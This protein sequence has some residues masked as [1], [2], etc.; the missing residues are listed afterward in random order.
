MAWRS[1]GEEQFRWAEK[2]AAQGGFFQ[3]GDC[4]RRGI[5][6]KED[7]KKARE[8]FLAAAE[9]GIYARWFVLALCL[10]KT[11]RNNLFGLEER[12]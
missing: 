11:I 7:T 1:N 9:L 2:S 6:R 10:G 12:L 5:A 3:L 4:C 8:Y